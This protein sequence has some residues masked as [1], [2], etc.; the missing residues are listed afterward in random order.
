MG[1]ERL[2]ILR[3]LPKDGVLTAFPWIGMFIAGPLPVVGERIRVRTCENYLEYL[4]TVVAVNPD[5][6]CYQARLEGG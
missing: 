2:V 1:K 5:R 4:A 3:R 6:H